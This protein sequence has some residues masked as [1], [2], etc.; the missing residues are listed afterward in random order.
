MFY[1]IAAIRTLYCFQQQTLNRTNQSKPPP[2]KEAR[3][4]LNHRRCGLLI[5]GK[6]AFSNARE[7]SRSRKKCLV[8]SEPRSNND[9]SLTIGAIAIRGVHRPKIIYLSGVNHLAPPVLAIA[10]RK[11]SVPSVRKRYNTRL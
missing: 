6:C 5:P 1:T 11:Q 3:Q 2:P 10:I 9:H 4:Q 7:M 8:Y